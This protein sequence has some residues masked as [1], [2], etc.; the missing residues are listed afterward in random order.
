MALVCYDVVR[1]GG[2]MASQL[3]RSTPVRAMVGVI[4]LFYVLTLTVPLSTRVYNWVPANSILG[5]TLRWT[6]RGGGGGEGGGVEILVVASCHRNWDRLWP[7][8]PLGFLQT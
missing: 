4:M 5:V 1:V 3:V 7:D 6:W 8:G 2:V